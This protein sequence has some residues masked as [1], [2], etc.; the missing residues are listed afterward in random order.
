[1]S[2]NGTTRPNPNFI[3]EVDEPE[4]LMR[5]SNAPHESSYHKAHASR[6]IRIPEGQIMHPQTQALNDYHSKDADRM[7]EDSRI[8]H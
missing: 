4:H 3:A 1:M 5:R 6:E 2:F 7:N 8:K